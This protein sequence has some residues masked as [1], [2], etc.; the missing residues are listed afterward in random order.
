[1][2]DTRRH[3][4]RISKKKKKP[5]KEHKQSKTTKQK[6]TK[7]VVLEYFI[8]KGLKPTAAVAAAHRSP[9]AGVAL[10]ILEARDYKSKISRQTQKQR[11]IGLTL[12]MCRRPMTGRRGTLLA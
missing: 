10:V 4:H 2:A 12:H 5:Y 6:Q 8:N 9:I 11:P 1:M 3:A 7:P